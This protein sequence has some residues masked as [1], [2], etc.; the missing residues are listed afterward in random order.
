MEIISLTGPDSHRLIM[1]P[2]VGGCAIGGPH[3]DLA[4]APGDRLDWT[5][6]DRFSTPAGSPWPRWIRYEGDD[7]GWIEWSTGRPIE[8]FSWTPHAAHD[9][10]LSRAGLGDFGLTLSH[11]PVRVVLPETT[12]FSAGG[13]LSLFTP[14]LGCGRPCPRLGFSP[15]TSAATGIPVALPVMPAVAAATTVAVHVPPLRQ[16]FDCASLL[17]FPDLRHLELSG[18]LTNLQ[19]LAE[20]RGLTGLEL[21]FVPDLA[22]LPSVE[23][24]PEL[25]RLIAWNVDDR[26]GKPLR[27]QVRR[28]TREWAYASV[29]RLRTGE[30]FASEY[31]LPFAAWP[32]RSAKVAVKAFRAARTTIDAAAGPETVE[33]AVRGFVA[34]INRLP[35]IE[36]TEREDAQVAV[37]QL[38]A[39]TPL[40]DLSG[41]AG[42]WFDETR[43]F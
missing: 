20:F 41:P 38:T 26:G 25:S 17:Q 43:E 36:T 12:R 40:G 24:W 2:G 4:V 32:T 3:A 27:A 30:W 1:A 8:G 13:D 23:G 34:A 37:A 10:D 39:V 33:E 29:S 6:F 11:A 5:V 31:G 21:R 18:S 7:T 42:V 28:S 14:V 9:I 16:P 15:R 22:G 35:R 19:A